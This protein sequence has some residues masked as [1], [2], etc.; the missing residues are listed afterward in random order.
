[1]KYRVRN[2]DGELEYESFKQVE[3]AARLGFVDPD[4][5]LL[6]EGETEWKKVS[7][8]PALLKGKR[9]GVSV[10]RTSLTLWVG[11]AVSAAVF[12][13]WAIRHGNTDDK[14]EL[15]AAGITAA[16]VAAGVLFKVTAQAQKPRR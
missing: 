4:D 14:P 3:D 2:K 10:F 8:L 12:A 1:M 6:R 15:Y 5:D 9:S 7:T 13:F 11:V 16:F